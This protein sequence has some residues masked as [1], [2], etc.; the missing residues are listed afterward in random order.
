MTEN[1]LIWSPSEDDL[2]EL[3]AQHGY[4]VISKARAPIEQEAPLPSG[5]GFKPSTR[6]A[7]R[8]TYVVKSER[9]TYELTG[10]CGRQDVMI[11][12]ARLMDV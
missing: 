10:I 5:W 4:T 1:I 6:P 9:F 11:Q 3:L 7:M 2:D 8:I 12:T